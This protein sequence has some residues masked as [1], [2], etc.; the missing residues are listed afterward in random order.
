[1]ANP[2]FRLYTEIIDDEKIRMLA[3]EDRWHFV[4]LLCLK[5]SGYLDKEH[6]PGMFERG[7]SV[8]LG[9]TGIDLE[10]LKERLMDV[11]LIDRFWQPKGWDKRQFRSDTDP[12]AKDRKRRQR[13]RE[14]LEKTNGSGSVT[15]VS[16]VTGTDVTRTEADTDTDTDKN[17]SPNGEVVVKPS[18]SSTPP[19][20]H[21]AI[22]DL[23]HEVLPELKVCRTW[24]ADRQRHLQARWREDKKRQN[25]DWW[26]R[27]FEYTRS[28]PLIMGHKTFPDGRVWQ[29]SLAT[30]IEP[31]KFSKLIDGEYHDE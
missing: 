14:K 9:V 31:K 8:K 3:F 7:I 4:A 28:S 30:L 21:K 18:A 29:P 16:R 5:N 12:T 24:G 1:M 23:F 2:W 20:P 26:R 19:C 27:L 22:V 11:D 13:E 25:L 6:K 15:D 17:T 10:N